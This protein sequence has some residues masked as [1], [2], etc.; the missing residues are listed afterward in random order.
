MK[1][2]DAVFDQ[3][4]TARARAGAGAGAGAA[5]T[6]LGRECGAQGEGEKDRGEAHLQGEMLLL[7]HGLSF[8]SRS[9]NDALG[10]AGP[11]SRRCF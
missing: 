10:P 7:F 6:G 4:A 5:P 8:V 3:M 1:V 9:L 11:A 2:R